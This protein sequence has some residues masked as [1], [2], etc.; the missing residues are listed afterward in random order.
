MHCC[1]KQRLLRRCADAM[2]IAASRHVPYVGLPWRRVVLTAPTIKYLN[3]YLGHCYLP[4]SLGGGNESI[5]V[6]IIFPL[7]AGK[8][9]HPV[10]VD[11]A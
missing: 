8:F 5:F 11:V 3:F 10:K 2:M 4:M 6:A 9:L 1:I 7:N